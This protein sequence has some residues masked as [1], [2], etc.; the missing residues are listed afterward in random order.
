M[1]EAVDSPANGMTLCSGSLGA[2]PDNDLLAM[3]ERFGPEVHFFAPSQHQA[4]SATLMHAGSLYATEHLEGTPIW[5]RSLGAVLREERDD[6]PVG[7]TR[8]F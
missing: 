4:S 3:M 1:L 5:W 8:T 2:W 6:P 7:P